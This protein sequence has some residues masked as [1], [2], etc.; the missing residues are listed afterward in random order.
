VCQT[1]LTTCVRPNGDIVSAKVLVI[2]LSDP[3]ASFLIRLKW[4][5]LSSGEK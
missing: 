4:M 5:D 1:V 2:A 3:M